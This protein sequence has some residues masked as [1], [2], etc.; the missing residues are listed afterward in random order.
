MREGYL[1]KKTSDN[2][3]TRP[4]PEMCWWIFPRRRYFSHSCNHLCFSSRFVPSGICTEENN[5]VVLLFSTQ[6]K[7]LSKGNVKKGQSFS[8]SYCVTNDFDFLLVM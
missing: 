8:F 3:E 7:L 4:W 5:L 1:Q 2:H 6:Y